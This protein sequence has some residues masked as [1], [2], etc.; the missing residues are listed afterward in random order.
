MSQDTIA[1]RSGEELDTGTLE[2]FLRRSLHDLPEEPL[3][4]QQFSGDIPI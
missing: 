4:I 1:V 2:R 3:E